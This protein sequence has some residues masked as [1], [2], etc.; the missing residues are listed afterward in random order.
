MQRCNAVRL[1]NFDDAVKNQAGAHG[2]HEKSDNASGG[3]DTHGSELFGQ[4]L[5]LSQ[6]E[7][8]DFSYPQ[9]ARPITHLS[10]VKMG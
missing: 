7:K 8:R 10:E 2:G 9:A 1:Q 3:I 5:G 4:L 6:T